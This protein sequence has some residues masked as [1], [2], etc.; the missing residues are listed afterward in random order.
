MQAYRLYNVVTPLFSFIDD[1]TNWYI[2]LNRR[3]FWE[4]G[5]EQDKKSAYTTLHRVLTDV[6]RLMAPFAPF[7]ADHTYIS[8][9]GKESVHLDSYPDAEE[10]LMNP[11]LETAV[12]RMQHVILLGRQKCLQDSVKV[13]TPLRR[14]SVVHQDAALMKEM[15][16]LEEYLLG[17]LNVKDVD[18]LTNEA[19]FIRL[20]AK[21]NLPI[22]GKKLGKEMGKFRG[23]I[24]ALDYATLQ[25]VEA[26]QNVTVDGIEFTP[27]EILVYREAKPGTQA[28]TNRF[29]TINM[30]CT[31]DQELIDEGLARE[32]VN[33]IQQARKAARL[34][35][36]DRVN[37]TL[38]LTGAEAEQLRG[39][40]LKHKAHIASETLALDIQIAESGADFKEG[41]PIL[42]TAC[43]IGLKTV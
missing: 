28:V 12:D 5:L 16:K 38:K 20:Y 22:L 4:E 40:L 35:V 32:F 34:N 27:E 41:L 33:R 26:G 25:K 30:D 42:E 43:A 31:L 37:V 29:I 9:T 21:A 19:D 8:L 39:V 13:K 3:R 14:L 7:L 6:S 23:K 24:E 36:S 17:E 2:R 11:T 18:Y 1:L 10:K 15:K